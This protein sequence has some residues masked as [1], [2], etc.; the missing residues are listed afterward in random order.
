MTSCIGNGG[1]R[2]DEMVPISDWG[3]SR[4]HTLNHAV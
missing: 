1:A 3:V 4:L 2:A